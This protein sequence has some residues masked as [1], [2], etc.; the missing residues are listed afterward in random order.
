MKV[1]TQYNSK[2][3]EAQME[4]VY[5]IEWLLNSV[6]SRASRCKMLSHRTGCSS[7]PRMSVGFPDAVVVLLCHGTSS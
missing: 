5:S 6:I 4:K 1:S 3:Q 2:I 7:T